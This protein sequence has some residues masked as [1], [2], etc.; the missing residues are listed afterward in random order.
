[1]QVGN[2]AYVSWCDIFDLFF[3][4]SYPLLHWVFW[5]MVMNCSGCM[6]EFSYGY[7]LRKKITPDG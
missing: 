6:I 2:G 4:F 7:V 5:I 1:M 3:F